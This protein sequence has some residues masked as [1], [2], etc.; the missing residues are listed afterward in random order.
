MGKEG[1]YFIHTHGTSQYGG[2]KAFS[3]PV[4]KHFGALQFNE[5]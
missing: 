5:H 4:A 3:N 2:V 1:G